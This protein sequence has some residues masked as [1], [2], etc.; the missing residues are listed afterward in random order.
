MN[1]LFRFVF[2]ISVLTIGCTQSVDNQLDKD[3][4]AD[5]AAIEQIHKDYVRGWLENDEELIMSLFEKGAMIQP[6]SLKH[7]SQ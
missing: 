1:L 6:S 2:L 3:R 5:K 7:F 4:L